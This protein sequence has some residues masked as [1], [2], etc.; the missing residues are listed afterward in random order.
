M[1]GF[2]GFW[3]RVG[4][5]SPANNC[6]Q[7]HC[8]YKWTPWQHIRGLLL[9]SLGAL[10]FTFGTTQG[11]QKDHLRPPWRTSENRHRKTLLNHFLGTCFGTQI[12]W[13]FFFFL[14]LFLHAFRAKEMRFA[15]S[16][17][18]TGK[19]TGRHLSQ[20]NLRYGVIVAVLCKRG[21]RITIFNY[22]I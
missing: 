3:V 12:D 8:S 7:M 17:A 9:M 13:Y 10:G 1:R 22:L 2:G 5:R 19:H 21:P 14:P 6:L 15:I 4:G 18:C 16:G 20:T 11:H